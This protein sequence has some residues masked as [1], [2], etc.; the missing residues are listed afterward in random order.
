[1][2]TGSAWRKSNLRQLKLSLGRYLAILAIVALGIAFFAGLK[3][4]QPSM[5]RTGED[6][7]RETS[8]YDYRLISTLGLTQE[9]VDGFIVSVF[10]GL[11]MPMGPMTG[12]AKAVDDKLNGRDSFADKLRYMHEAKQTTVEDI[13]AMAD[14]LDWMDAHGARVSVHSQRLVEQQG[15]LF[16]A[17]DDCLMFSPDSAEDGAEPTEEDAQEEDAQA[18]APAA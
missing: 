3:A 9:D 5:L 2:V 17:T 12:G 1:M 6:Y 14:I 18:E 10:S 8:F 13:R 16:A 15:S 11:S 7:L 4:A